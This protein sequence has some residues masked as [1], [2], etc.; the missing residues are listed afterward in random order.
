VCRLE[1]APASR[2][3]RGA[4][5]LRL[6]GR[7]P[8]RGGG[9]VG[10]QLQWTSTT[11]ARPG[12]IIAPS[13]ARRGVPAPVVV[14][15]PAPS[16]K[17][18]AIARTTD[19]LLAAG[20]ITTFCSAICLGWPLAIATWTPLDDQHGREWSTPIRAV[21]LR[22]AVINATAVQGR[23]SG[24]RLVVETHGGPPAPR[25]IGGSR[26]PAASARASL[27]WGP[28]SPLGWVV[29][30]GPGSHSYRAFVTGRSVPDEPGRRVGGW[31][32]RWSPT[33]GGRC[34]FTLSFAEP[35]RQPSSWTC[36]ARLTLRVHCRGCTRSLPGRGAVP[37]SLT[38]PEHPA[39]C[40]P[41]L[42]DK[43]RTAPDDLLPPRRHRRQWH[44][45]TPPPVSPCPTRQPAPHRQSKSFFFPYR[46]SG[47]TQD[48]DLHTSPPL[49]RFR[50]RR[51]PGRP[52]RARLRW[53]AVRRRV[54]G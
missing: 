36:R 14:L 53:V 48:S 30:S 34:S 50:C 6:S 5:H 40:V 2:P 32:S 35:L 33:G 21:G 44:Q 46:R 15:L 25:P 7:P 22:H 1:R 9:G 4:P 19:Y 11:P 47:S 51:D 24:G 23:A 3:V 16:P 52:E 29:R 8:G 49:I 18:A 54:R 12:P 27:L 20:A 13:A 10:F 38:P 43:S 26:P 31:R 42:S 39:S 41:P 45:V 17:R 37:H 28:A